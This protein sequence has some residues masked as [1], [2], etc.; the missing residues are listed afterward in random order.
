M[1]FPSDPN[2]ANL[3]TEYLF[4]PAFLVAPVTAQGQTT[5][6]VYLP[7]GTDWYDFWTGKKEKGGHWITV[8]APADRIPVFV[9]AGSIVPLG[10]DVQSTAEKQT[11]AKIKIYPGANASFTLYD[12]DGK[13]Y[14]YEKGEG[15]KLTTLTWNDKTKKLTGSN[16]PVEVVRK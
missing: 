4:G 9:R 11:I 16:A 2:V 6:R 10:S 15:V 1:D 7:A 14:A 5:A 12:D 13:T 3:G 8:A